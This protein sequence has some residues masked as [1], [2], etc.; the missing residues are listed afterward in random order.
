MKSFYILIA[1]A[2]ISFSAS[3]QKKKNTETIIIKTQ[4]FCDHCLECESCS[5][6]IIGQLGLAKGIKDVVI[7]PEANTISV[8]YNSKKTSTEKIRALINNAGFDADDQKASLE[9]VNKLDG[10]CKKQ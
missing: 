4:I 9:A 8:K 6:N 7:N 1:A 10:C 5:G 2:L 3:A